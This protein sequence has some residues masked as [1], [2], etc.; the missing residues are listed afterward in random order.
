MNTR[1]HAWHVPVRVADVPA[2]G[3]HLTLVADKSVRAA[4]A[5]LADLRDIARLEATV[6]ISHHGDGLRA[7]GT[8][9]AKVGQ[10]CVITLDPVENDVEETFDVTFAPRSGA[11]PAAAGDGNDEPVADTESPEALVDGVAEIGA[12]LAE[13]LLLGIDPYPKKPGAVFASPSEGD[14]DAGPFAAL[15][16]LKH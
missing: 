9:S 13:F 1:G 5:A 14:D 6:D 3:L 12:V 15:A 16:R 4:V 10:T 11:A 2:T 7:T 8:V